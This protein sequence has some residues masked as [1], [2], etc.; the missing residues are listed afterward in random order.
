MLR[1]ATGALPGTRNYDKQHYED[2]RLLLP[3]VK[4]IDFFFP[5]KNKRYCVFL[6][7]STY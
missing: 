7:I 4:P 6:K 2:L 3:Q 5:L 1:L